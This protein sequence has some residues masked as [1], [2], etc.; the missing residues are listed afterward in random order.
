DNKHVAIQH[1]PPFFP[2]TE[3]HEHVVP[4]PRGEGN[5]P[6]LPQV[7]RVPG[8]KWSREVERK[9]KAKQLRTT[10]GDVGVPREIEKHLHEKGEATRPC[11][12][13]TWVRHRIV[14][15]RV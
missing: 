8:Y 14:E 12:Q 15:V 10:T 13:P 9:L 3:R 4:H 5:V 7:G 2:P 6:P 1:K 11:S